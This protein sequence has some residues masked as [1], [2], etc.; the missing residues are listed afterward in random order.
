MLN[1]VNKIVQNRVDLLT[2]K[3]LKAV[4]CSIKFINDKLKYKV[5]E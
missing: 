4:Y 1:F 5:Y 3:A 2:E